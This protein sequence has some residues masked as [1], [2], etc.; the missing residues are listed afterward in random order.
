R[1][2]HLAR[3]DQ[4]ARLVVADSMRQALRAAEAR[5]ESEIYL[6]LPETRLFASNDQVARERKLQTAAEREAVDRRNDGYRQV[7]ET[8]H[9]AMAQARK[10]E[11]VVGR[12]FCHRRDIRACDERPI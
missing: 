3:H 1:V 4:L 10:I 11:S 6:G 7:L 8:F 12:H 5:D 2:E 9:H